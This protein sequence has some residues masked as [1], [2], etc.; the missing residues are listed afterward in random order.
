MF[1]NGLYGC[2]DKRGKM[3]ESGVGPVSSPGLTRLVPST[4]WLLK[5]LHLEPWIAM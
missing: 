5:H 3:C 4:S 1:S 2:I